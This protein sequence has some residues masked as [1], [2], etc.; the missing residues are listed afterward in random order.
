MAAKQKPDT[1]VAVAADVQPSVVDEIVQPMEVVGEVAEVSNQLT[2]I[3][4]CAYAGTEDIMRKVWGKYCSKPFTVLTAQ[5][6]DEFSHLL[7]L[8]IADNT[9]ADE[10]VMVMPNTIPCSEVSA[11]LYLPTVLVDANGKAHYNH[12]LPMVI[13]K[14]SA[15]E[16]LGECA[17]IKSQE[18]F[19]KA[20]AEKHW[21]RPVQV[22]L[23]FGNYV[24]TVLRGTPCMNAVAEGLVRRKFVSANDVG[25]AAIEKLIEQVLL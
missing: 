5:P 18:D 14:E 4:V 23:H 15:V 25:F 17:P 13:R 2:P 19:I 9:V 21:G 16:M 1:S 22:S 6:C 20:Y 8:A 7:T 3:V 12:R 11:E 24:T 10:F